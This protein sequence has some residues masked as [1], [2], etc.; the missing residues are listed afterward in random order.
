[1]N[2]T[3]EDEIKSKSQLKREMHALQD[4]GR[5]FCE[6]PASQRQQCTLPETL[7][8]AITDYL[9]FTANGARKRQLQYI[10]KLM[11]DIGEESLSEMEKTISNTRQHAEVEKRRL[12]SLESLRDTLLASEPG[13]LEGFIAEQPNVDIQHLRQLIRQAQREIAQGKAPAA[14]RKLFRYLRDISEA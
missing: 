10:G 9:G 14:S 3:P 1:M 12:H 13:A 11:R 4:L 8:S 6:L 2:D 5:R 7:A